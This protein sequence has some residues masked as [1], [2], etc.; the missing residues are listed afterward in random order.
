MNARIF[1]CAVIVFGAFTFGGANSGGEKKA[2]P[3][4]AAGTRLGSPVKGVVQQCNETS[5]VVPRPPRALHHIP[6]AV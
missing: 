2:D 5:A 4:Q 6:M 3:N 1:V